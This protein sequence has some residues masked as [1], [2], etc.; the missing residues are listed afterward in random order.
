MKKAILEDGVPCLGYLTWG[1]IDILS[2][3]GEMKKR[4]G[5]VFVNRDENDLRDMRRVKK[6]SFD[7]MKKVCYSH[8]RDL[9]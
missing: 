3:N 8:G 6:E 7:W 5:F 2:S 4:Y 9:E 1:P